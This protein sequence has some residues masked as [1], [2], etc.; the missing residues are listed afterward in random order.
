[1]LRQ[2]FF[3]FSLSLLLFKKALEVN[4]VYFHSK[5]DFIVACL[6]LFR[7]ALIFLVYHSFAFPGG[8]GWGVERS[9]LRKANFSCVVCK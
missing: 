9:K 7:V 6:L 2:H 4:Y 3:S 5:R 8:R 1:M